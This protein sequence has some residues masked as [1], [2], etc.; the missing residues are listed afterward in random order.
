[1]SFLQHFVESLFSQSISFP[2]SF[3]KSV[4]PFNVINYDV[5]GPI[6][7]ANIFGAKW[8]VSFIDDCT[9]VI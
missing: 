1:M 5:W 9:R 6:P 8:V 4:E 3:N 7:N 2:F